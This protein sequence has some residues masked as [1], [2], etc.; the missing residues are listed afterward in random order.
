MRKQSKRRPSVTRAAGYRYRGDI[1]VDRAMRLLAKARDQGVVTEFDSKQEQ[2]AGHG[3]RVVQRGAGARAARS[4]GVAHCARALTRCYVR[5]M[6]RKRSSSGSKKVDGTA[7]A[8]KR[9][10]L[11]GARTE[12]R[13]TTRV[14]AGAIGSSSTGSS[15][16]KVPRKFQTTR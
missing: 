16:G 12:T 6:G 13:V 2:R 4:P 1:D 14:Q 11:G 9:G 3:R 15:G 10:P 5:P 8:L 7:G